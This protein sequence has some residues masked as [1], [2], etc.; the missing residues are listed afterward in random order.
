VLGDLAVQRGIVWLSDRLGYVDVTP[1][2]LNHP[3]IYSYVVVGDYGILVVETGPVSSVDRL[4]DALKAEGYTETRIHVVVTHVHLDH[5]G[6][7]GRLAKLLPSARI[8]VHPRGYQH[9][10]LPTRLWHASK[11]ALG[12]LAEVYGEPEPVPENQL[13]ET[14]DGAVIELGGVTARIVHTPG[15]ASHHQSVLVDMGD[16]RLLFSGDSAGLYDP[17]SGAIAPTTPPPFRYEAYVSSL[18]RQVSL[19]PDRIAYTH[20]GVAKRGLELL[21]KHVEQVRLW[22][23]VVADEV[24]KGNTDPERVLDR[25]IE[26]DELTRRYVSSIGERHT[27]L[28]LA[29]SVLGFIED[30]KPGR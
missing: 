23:D 17:A 19:R 10:K 29:L 14:S 11:Q 4:V 16:E 9:L 21:Q 7:A 27:R 1:R 3:F 28:L 13:V 20:L 12:W 30:L 8:Y 18:E 6:G 22:R 15:H 26:V 25:I 2:E 24:R 5:G